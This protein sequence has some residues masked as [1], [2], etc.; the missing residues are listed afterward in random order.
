VTLTPDEHLNALADIVRGCTSCRLHECRKQ[1]VFGRGVSNAS[2]MIIGG[3]PNEDED[4]KGE[5]FAGKI[6]KELFDLLSICEVPD[7]AVYLTSVLK[8]RPEKN[9]FPADTEDCA[10]LCVGYL[11]K[12]I[13][14]IG[15]DVIL[16]AGKHALQWVLYQGIGAPPDITRAVGQHYR[17][18]D[19][20]GETRFV[21]MHH[22]NDL[23]KNKSDVDRE[24][25]MTAV[26]SAWHH[27]KARREGQST[28]WVRFTDL[29]PPP[30][31][32][33]QTRSLFR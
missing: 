4:K 14:V 3:A 25:S 30:P 20:F 17:R 26:S 29:V 33:F 1:A 19:R 31:P 28:P 22:P 10:P 11:K 27:A 8:C 32:V 15:P 12:Q 18:R 2:M 9:K 13:E 7:T 6:G 23:L 24:T 21:V 16:L 5:S